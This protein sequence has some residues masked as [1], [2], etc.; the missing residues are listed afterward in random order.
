MCGIAGFQGRFEAALL[1]SMTDTLAHRGPD[2]DGIAMLPVP[3][4]ATT[5]LGHRRLAIID[6]SSAGRQPMSVPADSPG[7]MQTGLTLVYNGEIYNY[8]ELKAEL[9]AEGHLFRTGTDS[10]VLLHLYE[11]DGLAM[12]DRLNGIFAFAIHDARPAGRPAGVA[13]GDIFIARDQLGVKP[14]YY[15]Q[16]SAG[17]LFASEM[18]ALLCSKEVSREV[19][20]MSLHYMLAYLWTP[21]PRTMLIGVQKLEPGHAL[22]VSDGRIAR[23]WC[24]Y[25]VPYEGIRDSLTFDESA[26]ALASHLETAVRRQLVSDVPVGAYLSGG[27]DSS[28]VVAMMRR[29]QPDQPINC[30]SIGFS[31]EGDTEGNPADLPYAR[32]VARHLRV[33]LHEIVVEPAAIERLPEM[34]ALLD[35]PQA[36]PAPINALLIAE[37]ARA[38][39]IPVLLS[40][41]GGDDLFSGYRRHWAA[42]FERNWSWLPRPLRGGLAAFANSAASGGGFGQSRPAFRRLAKMLAYA[43][44]PADRRLVT[45]FWWSTERMRHS[46]YTPAF[47]AQVANAD[48]AEPLLRSLDRIPRESDRLQRMLYLETKHFLADHNLNYTDRAGMATGVEVRVPLL[49]LDLVRFATRVPSRYKQRSTVGKAVFKRAMEPWLPHDVIYR[50]KSGFGA[51]LRRWMRHELR[52]VME[53]TL[54]AASLRRRGFFEPAAVT[55]LIEQDRNGSVDGSYTIFALMCLELWCRRFLDR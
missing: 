52:P 36:D 13:Q 20:P 34:V 48:T 44:E 28:A 41:A 53:A 12:L 5:G 16:T 2:G 42:V 3:G 50:P 8:R 55:R 33:D 45:Y 38:M 30:F 25:D 27:L 9:T 26:A 6:L 39:G 31:E 10:E 1:Q 18:K 22:L 24:Y 29:S 35:E 17:L 14:L 49:D 43:A 4:R 40:G 7:G 46:L 54:D 15:A 51:P 11:R 47:A 19:D 32:R 21:A 37:R 23:R